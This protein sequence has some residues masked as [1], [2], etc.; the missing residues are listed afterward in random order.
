MSQEKKRICV[1]TGTRAE[2]GLFVPLLKKLKAS[3]KHRLQVVVTGMHLS[4]EFGH[5]YK[6]IEEDGFRIDEKVEMLL[7]SDTEIGITK[8]VGIGTMAM[9]EAFNR[10]RPDLVFL[11]GDRFEALAAATAAMIARI[12]IAHVHGGELTEGAFDDSIRHAITKMSS[13]H[14]TA[15]DEYRRRVIQM[16]E[17]PG[18]VFNSGALGLDNIKNMRLLSR[19]EL[20]KAL[21]IPL[22]GTNFLVTF[23]PVT[24]QETVSTQRQFRALLRALEE[25]PEAR[26]IFTRPNADTGGRA[27]NALIDA[28]VSGSD[29]RASVFASMGRLKYLSAIKHSDAVV[30][31][32][33]SG[34][35]EAPSFGVPTV[36]IGDRQKG[37]IRAASVIDC[38]AERKAISGAIER[39]LSPQFTKACRRVKSPFGDGNAAERIVTVL[40]ALIPKGLNACKGFYDIDLPAEALDA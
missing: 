25:F 19:S 14:F 10:L 6:E 34:I 40:N 30:G 37:R 21:G 28:Y 39:A 7:S 20:A 31:N 9:A 17:D 5:T 22:D 2:Y 32:S 12:P 24:R 15:A 36:N 4:P 13:V 11:L 23:H 3:R 8:S 29:G 18:R 33:S 35:A 38:S 1:V 16:G 27:I 26:V